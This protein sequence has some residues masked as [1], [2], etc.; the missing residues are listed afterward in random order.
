M[1]MICLSSTK[2]VDVEGSFLLF[3]H[4]LQLESIVIRVIFNQASHFGIS[5][6]LESV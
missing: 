1:F 2:A 3:S 5:I 6:T 4:I